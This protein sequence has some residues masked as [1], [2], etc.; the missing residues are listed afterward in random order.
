MLRNT[1]SIGLALLLFLPAPAWSKSKGGPWEEHMSAARSALEM[2]NWDSAAQYLKEAMS[3]TAKFKDDD[4]RL[5]STYY[6][7]G[8][9]NSRLQNWTLAKEYY[10]RALA[11]QQKLLGAESL[12]AASALYGIALCH[13][14][15]GDH[16]AAEIFLKRVDEIWRKKLGPRDPRL[17]SILPSMAAYA[18][19]K[20]NLAQSESY[21]RQLV[22]IAQASGNKEK[23][24]VYMNLLATLLGNEGKLSEAKDYAQ[25]AV[26]ELKRSSQSSI[27]IDSASDNLMIIRS[28]LGE[29]QEQK[30]AIAQ[31]SQAAA[32]S[33][34]SLKQSQLG[35]ARAK[36]E[37]EKE[38]LRAQKIA[39]EAAR[40]AQE[41]RDKA[42]E[43]EKLAVLEKAKAAFEAERIAASQKAKEA[44]AARIAAQE[45]AK[46]AE[47]AR[48]AAQEKAKQAEEARIAA[49]KQEELEKTKIASAQQHSSS[50]GASPI[51]KADDDGRPKPWKTDKAI[52]KPDSSGQGQWGK[53][54]YLAD[55]KLISAEEYKGLLLANEAYEAMQQE[56]FRMAA[57][58]LN[59]ALDVCPTL[60]TAHTNLG[61]ALMRLG[62]S[63]E[64]IDH[65]RVAIALDDSR[66]APWV[67]LASAFQTSG[68]L[69]DSVETYK[70]YLRRFPNDGL[71]DMARDLCKH[72]AEEANEQAEVEKAIA[73]APAANDYFP[74]T[75]VSGTIKWVDAK[76][77]VKVYVASGKGVP[78]YKSE[79]QG[80]MNESFNNWAIASN[81]K[82]KFEFVG[83]KEGSDIECIWTNDHSQVSSPSEGGE[84]QVSWSDEGID[85]V[86]IVI[87]TVD[88]TPD[89]PLTQNQVQAVCLHEIGHSLGLIG[90]SP[91]PSDIMFCSMPAAD[92]KVALSPRDISTIKHLYAPDV[93]IA[94]KPSKDTLA[95]KGGG[96]ETLG[97]QSYVQVI[98]KLE[99]EL[100]ERPNDAKTQEKLTQAYNTY[101][102]DLASKGKEQEAESLMEKAVRLQNSLR[103]AALKI[104]TLSNYAQILH[105]FRKET[106][107]SKVES[108]LKNL[109]QREASN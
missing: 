68:R 76:Q 47:A 108:E 101:A 9:L 8:Q 4:S 35:L 21:Y 15:L 40:L 33:D 99:A 3:D 38:K 82:V 46:Q 71:A 65:L 49:Q 52:K 73:S 51:E 98:E 27:A 100:K 34:E 31:Q 80:I 29:Q 72:L 62:Q 30:P 90:H 107:A 6:E 59:K 11:Q 103:N 63:D 22:D 60:P 32:Q 24:G 106:E 41:A 19:L 105:K 10:E 89:S 37:L 26:D 54:R 64:A 53:V 95:S 13:Q 48:I 57:D 92:S 87:L 5:G 102:L 104:F 18:S 20:N 79:F 70:E 77:P 84:A 2:G 17:I 23:L 44:E 58:I 75:T 50:K 67:N 66:S 56:K 25:K 42:A 109:R 36:E 61:L 91:K 88:P 97:A 83:K 94:L 96:Q 43:A 7:F 69:K 55:G 45:K 81:N 85:H 28:K 86:K 93:H 16:L 39:Q 14:Q 74:Y 78:G 12:E 1:L